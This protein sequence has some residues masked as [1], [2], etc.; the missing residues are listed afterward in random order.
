MDSKTLQCFVEVVRTGGVRAAARIMNVTQPA[1]TA[2]LKRLEDEAGF[3]LFR[4]QGRG[5]VLTEQGRLFLP[6]AVAAVDAAREAQQ[7][8]DRIKEGDEG[9]LRVGYTAITALTV[10]SNIVRRFREDNPRVKLHLVQRTSHALEEALAQSELDV[11]LLH[12]PVFEEGLTYRTFATHS[13]LCAMPHLHPL[14]SEDTVSLG[15]LTDEDIVMVRRDIGPVIHGKLF[16]SFLSAGFKP[17]I[18]FETDNSI[19]LLTLV[20]AGLGI[21]FVVEP[22]S[23]WRIPSVLY[24]PVSEGLPS[25]SF[26]VCHRLR[27]VNPLVGRFRVS[28]QSEVTD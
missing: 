3:A 27:D 25:L 10:L 18:A 2:R 9:T 5:L 13:Y 14:A 15:S 7:S 1:L 17:N 24:K 19:S 8:A 11:A 4:R 26:C 16:E 6:R 20:S 22:L 21:G 23:Q 12:P 28:I